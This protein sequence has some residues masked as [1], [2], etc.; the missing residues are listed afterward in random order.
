MKL[1]TVIQTGSTGV[2]GYWHMPVPKCTHNMRKQGDCDMFVYKYNT[3]ISLVMSAYEP[4]G[5]SGFP[6]SGGSFPGVHCS[7]FFRQQTPGKEPL[8]AGNHQARVYP[9]F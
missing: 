7:L 6:A 3:I 8:L 1:I 4:S 5:P 2:T 9:D